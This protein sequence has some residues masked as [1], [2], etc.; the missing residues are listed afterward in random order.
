MIFTESLPV[1]AACQVFLYLIEGPKLYKKDGYYYIFAP[2]GGVQ[3]G[4]Q[5][6]LRAKNIYDPHEKRVVLP[7]GNTDINGPH[8]GG[9]VELK[10]GEWRFIHFQDRGAYG[11]IVHMQSVE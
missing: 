7:Q 11:R 1:S 5:A 4:W 3:T 9:L 10:S 2:P 6:V 8:Q